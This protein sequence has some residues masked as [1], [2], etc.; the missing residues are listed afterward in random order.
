MRCFRG[1]FTN[2]SPFRIS[3]HSLSDIYLNAVKNYFS[4]EIINSQN[5]Q[6]SFN[7]REM[8]LIHP[9]AGWKSKEWNLKKFIELGL[10]LAAQF[11][12]ALI[13]QPNEIKDDIKTIIK[14]TN[15]KIIETR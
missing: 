10:M 15:L 8:I 6:I 7:K 11:N 4:I 2:Y 13:S 1:I 9:F 12:C 5:N 14:D 3:K